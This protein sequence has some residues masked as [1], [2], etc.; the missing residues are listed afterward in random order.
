MGYKVIFKKL[1]NPKH[2]NSPDSL[3]FYSK[4]KFIFERDDVDS[5]DHSRLFGI[6]TQELYPEEK[7]KIQLNPITKNL[8]E[9]RLLFDGKLDLVIKILC[10][11]D[12]AALEGGIIEATEMLYPILSKMIILE[13]AKYYKL[14]QEENA[15]CELPECLINSNFSKGPGKSLYNIYGISIQIEK[16]QSHVLTD[17]INLEAG[18]KY[19]GHF[20]ENYFQTKIMCEDKVLLELKI[21]CKF[22]DLFQTACHLVFLEYYKPLKFDDLHNEILGFRI[23]ENLYNNY[24]I[25]PVIE[26]LQANQNSELRIVNN[27]SASKSDEFSSFSRQSNIE[28]VED[29]SIDNQK[30]NNEAQINLSI[31]DEI[32]ENN[33]A[34]NI[35]NI[36]QINIQVVEEINEVV[37]NYNFKRETEFRNDTVPN[38]RAFKK[39]DFNGNDFEINKERP[40]NIQL[41]KEEQNEDSNYLSNIINSNNKPIENNN[42]CASFTQTRTTAVQE[43]KSWYAPVFKTQ[44]WMEKY[45][46]YLK[47]IFGVE[48]D[49]EKGL[50]NYMYLEIINSLEAIDKLKN[51]DS[52]AMDLWDKYKNNFLFTILKN[53]FNFSFFIQSYYEKKDK[54]NRNRILVEIEFSVINKRNIELSKK[55]KFCFYINDKKSNISS[56]LIKNLTLIEICKKV[57]KALSNLAYVASMRKGKNSLRIN[58][59]EQNPFTEKQLLSRF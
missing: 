50:H 8:Y 12:K 11:D 43:N 15:S 58:P 16:N 14:I 5:L 9:F 35:S 4:A 29:S 38:R 3:Q 47:S 13:H 42:S 10:K 53:V 52:Y 41:R 17:K 22:E 44:V 39:S 6:I 26:N 28:I 31:P 59:A 25:Y 7:T 2:Y 30:E 46:I 51:Y 21:N 19:I 55:D 56:D 37:N 32:I 40:E 34:P 33:K 57:N 27:S 45:Y 24:E 18:L 49:Q 36:Q 48:V 20:Y 1:V 54:N 23:S